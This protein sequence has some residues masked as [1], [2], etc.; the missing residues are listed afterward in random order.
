VAALL[1]REDQ[2]E[3]LLKECQGEPGGWN[4]AGP[5]H[6]GGTQQHAA[7]HAHICICCARLPLLWAPHPRL[8]MRLASHMPAGAPL[9][10][11]FPYF[12]ADVSKEEQCECALADVA[13]WGL[14]D[15]QFINTLLELANGEA[16]CARS[17]HHLPV[18]LHA[19][20][21]TAVSATSPLQAASLS[22]T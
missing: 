19:W 15:G 17:M 9:Q 2:K 4:S 1:R 18:E 11:L 10:N 7:A 13:A 8:L 6:A 22:R 16:C 5:E 12:V 20:N 21:P 3:G 14:P